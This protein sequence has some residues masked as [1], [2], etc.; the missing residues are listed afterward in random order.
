[1]MTNQNNNGSTTATENNNENKRRRNKR[2]LRRSFNIVGC[3][4]F[5]TGTNNPKGMGRAF[6]NALLREGAKTIYATVRSNDKI[7]QLDDLVKSSDGRVVVVVLDVV[8]DI[9]TVRTLGIQY[10]D[11]NLVINNAGASF[12]GDGGNTLE[13]DPEK[14]KKEMEVNYF[15][16]LRVVQAFASNLKKTT[17]SSN[18]ENDDKNKT[19]KKKSVRST[20]NDDDE[21]ETDDYSS[22][23]AAALVTVASILSFRNVWATG[24]GCSKTALHYLTD[25]HRR[26]LGGDDNEYNT[27]VIGVYPGAIDTDMNAKYEYKKYSSASVADELMI[28]LKEGKEHLFPDPYAKKHINDFLKRSNN[29]LQQQQ[30]KDII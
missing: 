22:A 15:A 14:A 8:T 1:M 17:S 21:S 11:V 6:V 23:S 9:D 7:H 27:L 25:A 29:T 16:P 26:D 18:C 24:Y 20:N 28:A 30:Q 2:L 5:V 10:P 3:V 19:N 12:S 13:L 4:A